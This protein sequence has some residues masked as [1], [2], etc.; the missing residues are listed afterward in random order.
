MQNRMKLFFSA[1]LLIIMI[2][3]MVTPAFAAETET[4]TEPPAESTTEPSAE[5]TTEPTTAPTTEG[6]HTHNWQRIEADS[7]FHTV[8][9][10][11]CGESKTVTHRMSAGVC[12][13]CGYETH[14]HIMQYVG[15]AVYD[16]Q[17]ETKCT[18]CSATGL[19][20]HTYGSDDKCTVCGAERPCEH[21]W[22]CN[23]AQYGNQHVLIC[24]CGETMHAPHSWTWNA[25]GNYAVCTVC[26]LK[27]S[28]HWHKYI[29]PNG[30]QCI[31]C[32]YYKGTVKSETQPNET[33]PS[34]T[35]PKGTAPAETEPAETEPVGAESSD[36]SPTETEPVD[37][38][39]VETEVTETNPTEVAS[40]EANPAVTEPEASDTTDEEDGEV[41]SQSDGSALVWVVAVVSIAAGLTTGLFLWKKKILLSKVASDPLVRLVVIKKREWLES[42]DSSHFL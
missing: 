17:H 35:Q 30:T 4:T 1:V 23:G 9:C 27:D 14:T 37:T 40:G 6:V 39:P 32:G 25:A 2:L 31:E 29:Y 28:G 11:D 26:Q 33:E 5:P 13:V 24:A 42:N 19:E 36:T 18:S 8:V 22:T 16:S 12:T 15:G 20:Q 38:E 34:E 7:Q 21:Q 10:T 41:D 3:S